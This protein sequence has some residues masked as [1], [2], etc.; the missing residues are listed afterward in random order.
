MDAIHVQAPDGSVIQ[1]PAGTPDATI[2]SVMASEYGNRKAPEEK[3][4]LQTIREAVQAPTRI[5]ENGLFMG[6]GDRARAGMDAII[7]K[8]DY[9]S[10]LKNEQAQT[11]QFEADHP[12]SSTAIGGIGGIA[13]PIGMLGA[14][15]KATGLAGKVGYGAAAGAGIGG[16]QGGL[17][18][19]D[20][21]DL[22]QT[23]KDTAI[24]AGVGGLL[25]GSLPLAGKA[26][27]AGYNAL[28]DALTKPEG[29]SRGASRHLIE[30]LNADSPQAVRG[31]VDRLGP[32][33][34]LADT[35]PAMLGKAQGA[36]LNSDEGRS[37]LA[38]ALSSRNE[39]TNA[40]IMSDTNRALGPAEDPRPSR[41]QLVRV[42][43]RW[44]IKAYPARAQTMRPT[45]N[46]PY[47]DLS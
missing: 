23:A 3:G 6:L 17:S 40:R 30:A 42:A 31:Q 35:G 25:G 16:V 28:A 34:M 44:I 39:G 5:L 2:N 15:G 8:G 21:T 38:N 1:F 45:S 18:S 24:G 32:D 26:I 14:A 36:S 22:G 9:G 19:H 13:A 20:W 43:R 10:N 47:S 41:T 11:G 4:T 33:A 27:G 46:G 12:I 29:M 37:V 7:G